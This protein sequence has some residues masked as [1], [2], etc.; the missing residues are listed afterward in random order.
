MLV[1]VDGIGLL[2]R[3]KSG[4]GKSGCALELVR[5]GHRLVADDVVEIRDEA[6]HERLL[7]SPPA[8]IAGRLEVQDVGI[9]EVAT[10]FGPDALAASHP[11]DVVIDLV[12]VASGK[13]RPRHVDLPSPA[14]LLG[15]TLPTYVVH[16][17]DV[18]SVANRLEV[19]ARTVRTARSPRTGA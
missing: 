14:H 13:H 12:P 19:I 11:V 5:R 15:H 16:G 17:P 6:V 7:G 2:V 18:T 3:G 1:V 9:V 8:A 10:L 4:T